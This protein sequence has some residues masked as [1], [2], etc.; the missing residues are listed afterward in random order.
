[1]VTGWA[2]EK[3]LPNSPYVAN[4]NLSNMYEISYKRAVIYL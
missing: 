3:L 2:V 1:M 4:K